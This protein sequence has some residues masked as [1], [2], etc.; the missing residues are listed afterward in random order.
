LQGESARLR[1]STVT[2]FSTTRYLPAALA[3]LLCIGRL[4]GEP[5]P[6]HD[7]ARESRERCLQAEKDW[8]E[9]GSPGEDSPSGDA[10]VEAAIFANRPDL[11]TAVFTHEPTYKGRIRVPRRGATVP[12]R[13]LHRFST[14]EAELQYE[15]F[16]SIGN[17]EGWLARRI[18]SNAIE[19]WTAKHG[20]LFSGSGRLLHQATVHRGTG[21]GREWYGAFLPDGRWMTTDLQE[22]DGRLTFYS[23]KGKRLRSL[24]CEELAPDDRT[25]V[26][27]IGWGRSD[28]DGKGWVVNVG[29]EEGRAT[30]WVGP[31]G[32]PRVLKPGERWDLC[33]PR[34]LGPRMTYAKLTTC[35]SDDQD[36]WELSQHAAGH[37][38]GVEFPS[39][40]RESR[41]NGARDNGSA[42]V[43]PYGSEVFGFWPEKSSYFIGSVE[44]LEPDDPPVRT[45]ERLVR[46]DGSVARILN[47]TWFFDSADKL[48]ASIR[49]RRI[50]DAADGQ[51]MLFRVT[52]DS[53]IV[54]LS[55]DL[56]VNAVRRFVWAD[57][58]T[59][60]AVVLWDD[61]RLG[62][63]IR[64]ERLL[65]ASWGRGR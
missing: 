17:P 43:V 50:G 6:E 23:T 14:F 41:I 54:T 13:I 34:A 19:V 26:D 28:R 10:L 32:P 63:F 27:L 33:Y 30:V 62:L 29:S 3:I 57:G 21:W 60:D 52:A 65:L 35:V 5:P 45:R 4:H 42:H 48:L 25:H 40:W 53:R 1:I 22:T 38:P 20:W 58:S 49:A 64:N 16:A 8:N 37:G 31:T 56:R 47:I 59:A 15:M 12:L 9:A 51:S 36:Q 55:P 24:S 39:Y 2:S 44:Y 46:L 11:V 7:Y 18:T 61:L